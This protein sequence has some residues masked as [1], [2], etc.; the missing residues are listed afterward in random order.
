MYGYFVE[1]KLNKKIKVSIVDDSLLIRTML[2]DI[3]QSELRLEVVGA[4]KNPYEA[5]TMIK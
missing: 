2:T 1:Y 4:V 3:L 5:R